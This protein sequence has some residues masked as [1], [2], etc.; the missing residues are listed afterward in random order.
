MGLVRLGGFIYPMT[1]STRPRFGGNTYDP[2]IP[3]DLRT[4]PW[5]VACGILGGWARADM[6]SPERRAYAQD[7]ADLEGELTEMRD[8]RQALRTIREANGI[9]NESLASIST[10][11]HVFSG[12]ERYGLEAGNDHAAE[13]L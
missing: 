12:S 4:T 1:L 7:I 9:S 5:A 11:I 10:S 3:W 13:T 8:E 6:L 2:T